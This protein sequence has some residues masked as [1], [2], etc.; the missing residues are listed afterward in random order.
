MPTHPFYSDVLVNCDEVSGLLASGA[1]AI[2]VDFDPAAYGHG[3]IPG[4]CS[5][6]WDSQLRNP[7]THEVI[8]K[9]DFEQLMGG[10]GISLDTPVILYG[11][12]NNWFACW[13]FWMLKLYGHPNVRLVDGGLAK[14]IST[15]QHLSTTES[16]PKLSEYKSLTTD[17]R[18]KATIEDIFG[19]FFD[20]EQSC[21]LDVRSA[22]E[23]RG[24]ITSPGIGTQSKCAIAGHIPNAINI[25]WTL[26][27]NPDGTFKS[28]EC[29]NALYKS[30]DV[31]PEM[32]VITYC[33][34]GER[35][36]L[37]WFV[38]RHLLGYNIVLNYDRSMAHWSR[39]S[40]APIVTGQ[41]A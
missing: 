18:N 37:S 8:S 32:K 22:A 27:C 36:S 23:Y 12:N 21:L 33:A 13:A 30:F 1:R 35:A 34:I 20:G 29:L 38:L 31:R 19:S 28:P 2:Q 16:V 14:W 10:T 15:N 5:W 26:N 17:F 3:H 24:E 25:P 7:E 11:D 6:S 9:V 4:A 40:N 39:V 41:A